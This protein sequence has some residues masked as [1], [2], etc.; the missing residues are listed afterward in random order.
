MG[1]AMS[2]SHGRI[3]VVSALVF[4]VAAWTATIVLARHVDMAMSAPATMG[5]GFAAFIGVW[6]CMMTAMMVPSAA[7]FASFYARTFT[8][9][10]SARLAGFASGYLVIWAAAGVP[11]FLLA[12]LA[13][14]LVAGDDH[15]ATVFAVIV[16]VACGVYQLTPWKEQCLTRCRLPLTFTIE[17]NAYQGRARDLRA[18]VH[19]GAFCLGCCWSLMLLLI[20]FGM[21]N[22]GAMLALAVVVLAE[23]TWT[24]G[25]RLARTFGI[26][27]FVLAA[28][29]VVHPAI[30]GGLHV[31]SGAM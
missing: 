28:V 20:A 6:V 3:V 24:Q 5:L 27:A 8:H 2:D 17:H 15:L 12:K 16:F 25:P 29:A 1:G 22:I 18:G 30:A 10:R 21:M 26:G 7:P 9:R 11:V 13:D 4:A 14:H 23:K 31:T 19:H